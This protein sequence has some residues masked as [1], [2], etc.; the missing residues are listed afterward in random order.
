VENVDSFAASFPRGCVDCGDS[1]RFRVKAGDCV[2]NLGKRRVKRDSRWFAKS[3]YAATQN[4]CALLGEGA[5]GWLAI[6]VGFVR[7]R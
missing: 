6:V 3:K 5:D 2:C 1:A 4:M 7:D